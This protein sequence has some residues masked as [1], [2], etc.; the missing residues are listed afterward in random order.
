MDRYTLYC[1]HAAVTHANLTIDDSSRD[2][3]GVIL[4]TGIGGLGTLFEQMQVFSERGPLRVSPFLVPMMLPDS[5]A[6]MIAIHMGVRGPNM[7]VVTACATGTNALG[8]PPKSSAATG[9]GDAGRRQRSCHRANRHG[10][11]ERYQRPL[12]AQ[13]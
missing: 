9:G 5:A 11:H 13:R 4:G 3:I 2:Q 1:C 7:A 8:E 10:W 6:G 12:Y